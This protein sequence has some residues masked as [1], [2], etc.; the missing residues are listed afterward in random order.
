[1]YSYNINTP[2]ST[3]VTTVVTN[4]HAANC[5]SVR[6]NSIKN[7]QPTAI[8][9]LILLLTP[10][11]I[12]SAPTKGKSGSKEERWFEVELIVFA[13]INGQSLES[14]K[15]P[16]ITDL[17][18]PKKM[19][20]LSHPEPKPP[21]AAKPKADKQSLVFE[22]VNPD[23]NSSI[24]EPIP[25][26]V[27]FV[28]LE[29]E[30]LQLNESFK[31]LKR[32]RNFK[33]LLHVAWRQPT[34]DKKHAQPVLLY[35]GMTEP[36][37]LKNKKIRPKNTRSV[38]GSS[39]DENIE[40]MNPRFAGTIRLSV[41]RYLHFAA[42]LVYRTPVTQR[43]AIPMSSDE[44]WNDTPYQSLFDPQGPA[45]KLESWEAMR[46]FRLKESRRMRSKRIH[47]LDHPFLGIVVLITP[48]ELPK[49]PEELSTTNHAGNIPSR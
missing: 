20:E 6:C 34:F 11:L 39:T 35:E 9:A 38:A 49:D 26:P 48:V 16:E 46:G 45:V 28:M 22:Q 40:P 12:L 14:E 1:M 8:L 32:S 23:A 30:E 3:A 29:D 47:Y 21:K 18:L 31:K 13:H 43:V 17:A 5:R 41:A 2:V 24:E 37:F 27:A 19:V 42:D 25:M 10:G 33:P 44:L 15:W 4:E 36:E 7:W